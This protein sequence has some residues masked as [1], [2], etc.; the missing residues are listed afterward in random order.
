M[1]EYI[2]RETDWRRVDDISLD[3]KIGVWVDT[4]LEK[5]VGVWVIYH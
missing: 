1:G 4:P 3:N 5:Q 2:I